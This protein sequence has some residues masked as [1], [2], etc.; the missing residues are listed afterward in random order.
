MSPSTISETYLFS[1]VVPIPQ[2][3]KFATLLLL[4]TRNSKLPSG[5]F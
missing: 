4:I 1:G 5:S 3:P 2:V